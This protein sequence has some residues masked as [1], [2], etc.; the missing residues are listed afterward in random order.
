M[1]PGGGKEVTGVYAKL[2]KIAKYWES[3]IDS[4]VG[5]DGAVFA[6]RKELFRPL[7]P[8]D[9]NDFIIPLNV[10]QQ[11]KRVVLDPAVFCKEEASDSDKKAFRRQ[12]RITTRTLWAIRKHID[13]MN[14]ANY[15]FFAFF[16]LSH[17]VFRLLTPFFFIAA[18]LL[19][20]A[21]FNTHWIFILTLLC[22]IAFITFGLI[23]LIGFLHNKI[24][25]ISKFFLLTLLAQ[26]FG[27]MRMVVGIRDKTWTP[28]R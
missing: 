18:F 9:I 5:A 7:E 28:Q 8:D 4:C 1:T 19:N 17:K 25:L 3:L 20:I 12:V 14:F 11:D 26:S 6:I 27:W 2:E 16:L 22:F 21:I 10:I 24:G 15:R 23:N 13:L